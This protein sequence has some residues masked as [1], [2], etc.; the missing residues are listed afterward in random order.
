MKNDKKRNNQKDASP[1]QPIRSLHSII[2]HTLAVDYWLSISNLSN[3]DIGINSFN[4]ERAFYRHFAGRIH[5]ADSAALL[6]C[7]QRWRK[8]IN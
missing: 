3:I 8:V 4:C 5:H 7:S 6:T 2:P 1:K